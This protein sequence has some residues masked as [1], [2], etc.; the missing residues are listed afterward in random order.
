[1]SDVAA[2]RIVLSA[3]FQKGYDCYIEICDIVDENSFGT[4]ETSAIYKCL[5]H[6]V[7]EK[8]SKADIPS[9]ISV[10]KSLNIEDFFQT[11]DQA[12]Y[13][14]SLTLLPV[15]I[16][17]AKKAAAKLKKIQIAKTLAFNLSTCASELMTMT[18]DEPISQIVSLAE[19]TVLDQTFKISN[20]EDPSP[21]EIADGL[22]EYV[23]FLEENPIS[24]LGISS[25]FKTYDR[26]IGGG[27]RPGTVNL[28][29]AR[30]KTGK[31]FFADNVALNV[32]SQGIPVL[33][34][35]TEMTAKDHWHRLLASLGNVRIEEIENGSFAS[36]SSKK[37]K[38]YEAS[39]KLKA[40]PFK[41]KT[42]AGKSFDEVLSLARRWVIKDVGFD[43]SGK[44]KPC[45]IILDYIKL[46]DDS[47]I[48]KNIAEYQAL[49]FL[50]TSLHNFM[51]QY[52][53]ACLAFT[54]L[55]R[56]G[57]TREDTDVAS[58][59][60]RILWLCSNFS[61]YK[62][63]T[64]EE[65]ADESVADNDITYNLKLIPVVARHGKGID[66]GDYINIFGNYEY[67]KIVEG[68]TRNE[69]HNLRS[70]RNN[71][72]FEVGELNNEISAEN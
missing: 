45:L 21:K 72:G 18:G 23:K 60:D 30:M 46:M 62:R 71:S 34:F 10:A 2:E 54:Q 27:L 41:Y 44:A 58:G 4:P 67:G 29:G 26:A 16:V 68:P 43:D 36:D 51:V 13:I 70:P 19:S 1:M 50:M 3:L 31:S 61:I 37:R 28:I 24:Q 59:S 53:V 35:D 39:S 64:E 55:N 66:A 11:E 5:I 69:F 32:A 38:V 63:K 7:N 57:I 6:I 8:D 12:K 42:I 49:G 33:M 56:D 48:S 17:N 15:E 40:I 22:E 47:G 14:R 65:M 20:T 52:G 25:G 9:I